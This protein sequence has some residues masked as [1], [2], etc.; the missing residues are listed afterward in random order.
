MKSNPF[1]IL[2]NKTLAKLFTKAKNV[3][4]NQSLSWKLFVELSFEANAQVSYKDENAYLKIKRFR[5][6]RWEMDFY[7]PQNNLLPIAFK[8]FIYSPNLLKDEKVKLSISLD[9][10]VVVEQIFNISMECEHAGWFSL[11][12]MPHI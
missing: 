9:N 3:D 7:K 4:S 5:A 1:Y 12:H 6:N 11:S 8:V 10:Q 2:A